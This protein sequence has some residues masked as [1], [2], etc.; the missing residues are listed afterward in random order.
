MSLY[1]RGPCENLTPCTEPARY[2]P[3]LA[4][5]SMYWPGPGRFGSAPSCLPTI[6]ARA[7]RHTPVEA[8]L[9]SSSSPDT[10]ISKNEAR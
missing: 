5:G 8:K 9:A 7:L 4:I 3:G 6:E 10:S 2:E 1:V